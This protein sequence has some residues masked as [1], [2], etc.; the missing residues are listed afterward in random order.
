[1]AIESD[2][3]RE[4]STKRTQILRVKPA[5]TTQKKRNKSMTYMAKASE[6]DKR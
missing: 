3:A 4:E 5:I 6:W 2:D 1:M